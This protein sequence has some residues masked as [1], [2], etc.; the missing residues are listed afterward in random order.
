VLEYR[1]GELIARVV[2][3]TAGVRD[4]PPRTALHAPTP[5]PFSSRARIRFE[6]ARPARAR[7]EIL[8]LRGRVV[9]VVL[10]R[11]LEAGPH[12]AHWTGVA[13]HD[14]RAQSGVYFVRLRADGH[15]AGPPRRLAF[16]R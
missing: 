11:A 6:L 2:L 12:E 8:D 1:S 9:R 13:Q 3:P 15:L 7:V 14:G 16:V 5:N 10:D 4:E